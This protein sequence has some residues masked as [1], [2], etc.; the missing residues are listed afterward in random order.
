M[1]YDYAEFLCYAMFFFYI[2]QLLYNDYNRIFF[3]ASDRMQ[4]IYLTN[5]KLSI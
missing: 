5:L 2:M 4:K 1:F 3:K